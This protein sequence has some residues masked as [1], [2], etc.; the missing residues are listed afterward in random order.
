[1]RRVTIQRI[2]QRVGYHFTTVAEAL[3]NG[4]RVKPST[5]AKIQAAAR[6]MGYI[7]DPMLSALSAYRK[8]IKPPV[9]RE[10]LAWV[11][12]HPSRDE[13][14]KSFEILQRGAAERATELGYRLEEFWIKRPGLTAREATR[15]LYN[16]GIRGLLIA[17]LFS[18]R[19]HLSLEWSRFSSVALGYTLVRPWMNRV[20]TTHYRAVTTAVRHLRAAGRR[21]IGWVGSSVVDE[22]TDRLWLSGFLSERRTTSPEGA[23]HSYRDFDARRFVE[24][25]EI[26]RPDAILT[27]S[28]KEETKSWMNILR[29][30]GH[31]VPDD[32]SL[33][34]VNLQEE[35][36]ISGIVE[37]NFLI[38]RTAV[39]LLARMLQNGERGVPEYPLYQLIDGKWNEGKTI[40]RKHPGARLSGA[41]TRIPQESAPAIPT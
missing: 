22:R 19:G 40:V 26:F 9:Y 24:W 2:A 23:V 6:E 3:K 14:R 11:T 25:F 28:P 36:E 39:D 41:R 13:W 30:R 34:V 21:R 32:I 10:T 16:R 5:R 17:P 4:V 20:S 31:R 18:P 35:G 33:A 37:P 7:P 15:R 27:S 8:A 38:G 29:K 1:M 12:S